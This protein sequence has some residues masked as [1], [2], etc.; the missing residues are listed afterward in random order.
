MFFN[1]DKEIV[2]EAIGI[3][4]IATVAKIVATCLSIIASGYSIDKKVKEFRKDRK[5][6]YEEVKEK[7]I[8]MG[9]KSTEDF[10]LFLSREGKKNLGKLK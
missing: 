9:I 2:N 3:A 6:N 5:I 7:S 10:I 1:K 8:K 4:A